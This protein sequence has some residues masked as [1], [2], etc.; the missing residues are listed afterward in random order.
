MILALPFSILRS[1]VDISKAGFSP[2]KRTAIRDL[3]MGTNSKLHLQFKTRHWNSLDCNGETFADSYQNTWEVTR[4]QRGTAGILVNYT[5]GKIGASFGS[6]T[7]TGAADEFLRQLEPVLPG[8]TKQWNRRATLDSWPDYRG[9]K[10]RTRTGRSVSTRHSPVSNASE[11][12]TATS[13]VSTRRSTFR[14]T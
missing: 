8:I 4:A 5:G 11:R 2:R 14:A 9:R 10:A 13:P 6:E 1:S 7:A 12:A 3:G